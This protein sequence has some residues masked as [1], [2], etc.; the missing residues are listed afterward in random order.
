MSGALADQLLALGPCGD[1]GFFIIVLYPL[2]LPLSLSYLHYEKE[3]TSPTI[4]RFC[5]KKHRALLLTPHGLS[6]LDNFQ[7]ET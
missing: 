7:S 1:H 3:I 6:V 2:F 5:L 4:A